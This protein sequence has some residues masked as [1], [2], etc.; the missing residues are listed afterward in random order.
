M[1]PSAKG[2][3]AEILDVLGDDEV[4]FAEL[5]A[6]LEARGLQ[7]DGDQ[8]VALA[9]DPLAVLWEAW[10][11]ELVDVVIALAGEGAVVLARCSPDRYR[12]ARLDLPLA[13]RVAPASP[14]PTPSWLPATLRRAA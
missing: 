12:R 9:Q 10:P 3:A 11:S 7:V 1:R 5:A 13:P 6:R 2:L 14:L 8:A 4:T